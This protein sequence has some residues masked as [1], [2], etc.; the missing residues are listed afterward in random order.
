MGDVHTGDVVTLTTSAPDRPVE[1][2]ADPT[3]TEMVGQLPST[4]VV[5]LAIA[6]K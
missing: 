6:S 2:L 4:K 5:V 1:L 3:S